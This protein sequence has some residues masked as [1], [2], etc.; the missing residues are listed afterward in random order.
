MTADKI[1]K[2]GAIARLIEWSLNNKFIVIFLTIALIG[3]GIWALTSI[4]VDAFPD[5]TKKA[6]NIS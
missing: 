2:D 6:D 3:G 5:L 1:S 4:P